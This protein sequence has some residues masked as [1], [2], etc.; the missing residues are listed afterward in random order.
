MKID[1]ENRNYE[2]LS[3]FAINFAGARMMPPAILGGFT[4][5]AN[6]FLISIS[7][8]IDTFHWSDLLGIIFYVCFMSFIITSILF[9][10]YGGQAQKLELKNIEISDKIRII[11]RII[12]RINF[13]NKLLVATEVIMIFSMLYSGI[14][15]IMGG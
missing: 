13:V 7:Q 4:L 14:A 9:D 1:Y 6:I 8:S 3:Y 11:I 5:T 10:I 12:N 2:E 15:Y